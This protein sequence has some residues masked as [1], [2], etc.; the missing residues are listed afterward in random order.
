[1]KRK[2]HQIHI[3]VSKEIEKELRQQAKKEQKYITE[4]LMEG[5]EL[6]KKREDSERAIGKAPWEFEL[7]TPRTK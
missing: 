3:V 6:Y 7:S 1:M 4:L 2:T 5:W